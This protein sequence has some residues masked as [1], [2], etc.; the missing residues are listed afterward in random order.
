MVTSWI[1][2]HGAALGQVERMHP[3]LHYVGKHKLRSMMIQNYPKIV[4]IFSIKNVCFL[5]L[6][7]I[8]KLYFKKFLFGQQISFNL[9]FQCC[10]LIRLK[11]LE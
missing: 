9:E 10:F 1:K 3:F 7:Q 6:F 11:L 2:R 8:M 5:H 4:G